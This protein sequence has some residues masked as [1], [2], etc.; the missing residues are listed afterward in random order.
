MTQPGDYQI[1]HDLSRLNNELA[2]AQ[3]ELVLKSSALFVEQ[4]KLRVTL[5]SIHDGAV[6][7]GDDGRIQLIN[8]A[9]L[10]LIGRDT[11]GCT[12]QLFDDIF[13]ITRDGS[14]APF[15]GLIPRVLTEG[16]ILTTTEELTL[17]ATGRNPVPI[18]LSCSPITDPNGDTRG[19]VII[20]RDVTIQR[21]MTQEL[22]RLVKVRTA[23]LEEEIG[24]RKEAETVI[25]AA[26]DEKEILLRELHHRVNNNLQIISSMLNLQSKKVNDPS[27]RL[28]LKESLNR[29][30]TISSVH[31]KLIS[32]HNLSRIDLK[33]YVRHLVGNLLILYPAPP[34]TIRVT[35]E[36]PEIFVDINT[37][38]P[39]GLIL[40]ELVANSLKHAF[41]DGRSGEVVLTIKDEGKKLVITCRDNG[42][43]MPLG[44]DWE[45]PETVGLLLI[46]SL[47]DQ[48]QGTVEKSASEGTQFIVVVQKS[49]DGDSPVR[50]TY[51]PVSG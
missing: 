35:E 49:S 28:A 9:A 4:E 21:Q 10:L 50:G 31:E 48:L 5:L 41:P 27:L 39:L 15:T 16:D 30:R 3:R 8:P 26:L 47:V 40:N 33:T 2:A 43:G 23:E 17:R 34:G 12:G 14:G 1:Y 20:L 45:S 36:V 42:V 37:A 7:T 6:S 18:E 32:S 46:H 22:N 44:Y 25:R 38:I 19:V 24:R 51:N 13:P 29:I 11:A